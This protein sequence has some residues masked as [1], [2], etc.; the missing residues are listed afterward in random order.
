MTRIRSRLERLEQHAAPVIK[1]HNTIRVYWLADHL[2]LDLV[3]FDDLSPVGILASDVDRAH[4]PNVEYDVSHLT[5]DQLRALD[6]DTF[7][8]LDSVVQAR[9]IDYIR[10]GEVAY[11]PLAD[12]FGA[13]IATEAFKRAGVSY[14]D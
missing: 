14:D 3:P 9:M 11:Q 2:G 5:N 13:A 1:A 6:P 10:A 8:E 12:E 7:E 4:D